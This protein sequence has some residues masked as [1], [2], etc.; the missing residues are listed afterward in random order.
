MSIE[1][2]ETYNTGVEIIDS[3]HKKLIE[4]INNLYAAV[5]KG[6]NKF[7]V[8]GLL[9][10]LV[11]YTIR[12]FA[13]EEELFENSNYPKIDSLKKNHLFFTS[14]IMESKADQKSGSI[15]LSLKTIDFLKDLIIQ[16]ILE[17]DKE[18]AYF[19]SKAHF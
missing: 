10:H 11:D 9:D 15:I 8:S 17:T 18:Y 6:E 2:K 4:I 3:Q 7:I 1:W 19:I 16:H 14:K 12:H 5:K 13:S